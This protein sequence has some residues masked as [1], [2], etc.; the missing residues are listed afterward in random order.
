MNE[1]YT[2]GF[3]G[4]G[5]IATAMV[6]GFCGRVKTQNKILLSNRSIEKAK[7]LA[8]RF[9]KNTAVEKDFQACV[10]KSDIVVIAVL[11]SAAPEVIKS[12]EFKPN[13]RIVT[14]VFTM[15]KEEVEPL[16][17][18]KVESVVHMLPGTFVSS[19][20]GPIITYPADSVIEKVFGEIGT[21]VSVEDREKEKC[22]ASLTG[23]FAPIFSVADTLVEWSREKGVPEEVAFAYTTSLFKALAYE[24]GEED[25]GHLHTLATVNTPGGVNMQSVE[26][27]KNAGGF[28]AFSDALDGVLKRI[29]G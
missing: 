8:K 12:L 4:T 6:E 10:D 19:V 29:R 13:Q 11:P 28:K 16:L 22:L 15:A 20:N 9:P 25:A 18:C 2:I 3:I 27:I 1:K 23:M 5:M 21:I 24:A 26:H 7:A 14:L 17:N